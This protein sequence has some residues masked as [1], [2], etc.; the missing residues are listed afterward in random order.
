MQERT[1]T[2]KMVD[3][4]TYEGLSRQDALLAIARLSYGVEPVKAAEIARLPIATE[5]DAPLAA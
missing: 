2:L 5:L 3:G 4:R 1:W